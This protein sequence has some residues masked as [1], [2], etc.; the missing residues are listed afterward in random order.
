MTLNLKII[1]PEKVV[2][3]GVVERVVVPGTS[4]EFEILPNHAPII[5][6]LEKGTIVYHDSQGTHDMAI[7]GG[8]VEVQKNNVNVCVEL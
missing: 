1:S 7:S 8:F 2:F 5:S 3:D 6:T 4:G